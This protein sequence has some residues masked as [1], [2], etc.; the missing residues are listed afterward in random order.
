MAIAVLS[1][2]NQEEAAQHQ[3]FKEGSAMKVFVTGGN[4]FIGS[5]VVRRL[6]RTGHRVRC[7]VRPASGTSR[8]TGL[9]LEVTVGD[10]RDPE[11]LI[12]G[13]DG[14]NAVIHLAA[15]SAWR[16]I[17]SPAMREIVV[18]GTRNVL[19]AAKTHGGLRTVYVSSVAAINGTSKPEMLTEA[20]PWTLEGAN[21]KYASAKHDAEARCL[22]AV[23]DGVPVVI[24]NP[25][26]V[27]GPHDRKFVTAG[28]LLDFARSNPVL[29]CQ[30]G[31]SVVHVEDVACGIVAA[32]KRGR[33]GHRYIL[34]GEN[35]SIREMAALTLEILG[36]QRRI[37]TI[38][39]AL[40]L[41][42]A[43]IGKTLRVPLPFDANVIPYATRYWYVESTKAQQE[44]GVSFR[45]ARE[46]FTSVLRWAQ[47]KGHLPA[48]TLV[49]RH[50]HPGRSGPRSG[51]LDTVQESPVVKKRRPTSA[52]LAKGN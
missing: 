25:S 8:I 30:G 28:E 43:K 49:D 20:S 16:E 50:P 37:I 45:S 41:A 36:L 47:A 24:V 40:S 32:L 3:W 6:L 10:I 26:E 14:C 27:F 34:G 18:D 51:R 42:V 15:P 21:L 44:L 22:E 48:D 17:E 4:G 46:T 23:D 13:M 31:T 52:P 33:P 11:C 39:N 12:R 19:S 38:P 7:L 9:P 5:V 35:L 2:G 29:V 1:R